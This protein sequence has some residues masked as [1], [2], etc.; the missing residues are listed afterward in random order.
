MADEKIIIEVKVEGDKNAGESIKKLGDQTKK[1]KDE[2]KEYS[3]QLK[4]TA[5]DVSL[6]VFR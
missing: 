3:K 2:T 4:D 6:W 5:G 1:T